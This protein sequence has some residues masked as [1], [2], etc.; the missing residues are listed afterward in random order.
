MRS[1]F[2]HNF[3]VSELLVIQLTEGPYVLELLTAATNLRVWTHR[4]S[5]QILTRML[6]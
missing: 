3:D 6:I 5:C 4:M 2:Q 1:F